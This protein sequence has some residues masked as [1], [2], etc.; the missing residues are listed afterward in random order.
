M[1]F[2]LCI[3]FFFARVCSVNAWHVSE[4]NRVFNLRTRISVETQ[5]NGIFVFYAVMYVRRT[6][7]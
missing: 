1:V 3:R 2:S 7:F 6:V 5:A 4:I